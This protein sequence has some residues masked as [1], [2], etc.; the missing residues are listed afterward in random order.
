[1][2]K[3]SPLGRVRVL[4]N[5]EVKYIDKPK[6]LAEKE[7]SKYQERGAPVSMYPLSGV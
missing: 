2:S 3:K 6:G 5:G 4:L 1:M 7:F